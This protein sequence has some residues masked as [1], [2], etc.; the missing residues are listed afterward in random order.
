MGGVI[1]RTVNR[2]RFRS[3]DAERVGQLGPPILRAARV[4]A[5]LLLFCGAAC[6][7]YLP[8]R[9]VERSA[10]FMVFGLLP[11]TSLYIGG[12]ILSYFV[13]LSAELCEM[14]V[15]FCCRFIRRLQTTSL[16]D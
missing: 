3:S 5:I 6:A 4:L 2:T 15:V 7:V 10:T 8:G 14:S 9:Y 11:S 12:R 13:G 16:H 1:D